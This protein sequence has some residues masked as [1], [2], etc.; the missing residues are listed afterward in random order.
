MS[1]THTKEAQT[2]QVLGL[3]VMELLWVQVVIHRWALLRMENPRFGATIP[4]LSNGPRP[5]Q[6]TMGVS[7][8]FCL[9]VC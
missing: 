6:I 7:R 5:G 3:G 2:Q 9:L 4:V 1:L 8:S